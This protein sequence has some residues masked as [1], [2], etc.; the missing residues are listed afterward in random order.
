[1]HKNKW[2]KHTAKLWKS[3]AD[4]H[5]YYYVITDPKYKEGPTTE[6]W[7][8]GMG[9]A[10]NIMDDFGRAGLNFEGA[11]VAELGVG[12]GR[13]L[14]NMTYIFK[15]A[16]GWDIAPEMLKIC[17]EHNPTL[18][19]KLYAGNM[20]PNKY[21][22]VFSVITLQ[23]NY[24]VNQKMMIKDMFQAAKQ[25]VWF[26]LPEP[27]GQEDQPVNEEP[28][29]PMYGMTQEEVVN[30]AEEAGFSLVEVDPDP[31]GCPNYPSKQYLF[32]KNI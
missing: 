5:P 31:Y 11:T 22:C 13:V 25:M 15:E 23:H 14:R 19:T 3:L 20:P 27:T 6:F 29:V 4:T 28:H 18:G 8:S 21:D 2:L 32:K 1:M 16:E 17:R 12:V 30:L 26:N 9:V 7:E 10:S 24:P